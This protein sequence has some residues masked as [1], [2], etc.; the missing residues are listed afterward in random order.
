MMGTTTPSKLKSWVCIDQQLVLK[1]SKT[2]LSTIHIYPS[3]H[4]ES[5]QVEATL[6]TESEKHM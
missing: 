1:I 3:E 6:C 4:R 2:G 5:K